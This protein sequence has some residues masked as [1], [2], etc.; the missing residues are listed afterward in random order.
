MK[1]YLLEKFFEPERWDY[2]ISKA[3]DK[4]MNRAVQIQ[5]AKPEIRIRLMEKIARGEYRITPPHTALIPKDTPGEF[6]TVYINEDVDRVLLSILNDL[7]FDLCPEMVHPR[8]KSYL[9]GTGCGKVVQGIS[10][11]IDQLSHT[12]GEVVGWKSDLSKY[13][14]SVPL[15][16]IDAAFDRVEDKF[17][18]S[19]V[20]DMVRAYYHCDWYI[21]TDWVPKQKY[22]SLK[23]GC[24][25]ASW[26]ADVLLYHIDDKLSRMDVRYERYSDDM[27]CI[28]PDYGKA[29]ETLESELAQMEM[30]L[31]PKKVEYLS[32]ERWF[33]FLGFSIKGKDISMSQTRLKKFQYEVEDRTLRKVRQGITYEAALK[34]VNRY[35]YGN[36]EFSWATAVLPIINVRHDVDELNKF[37]M[38]CL[39]AVKAKRSKGVGGLG[40]VKNQVIGCITR[41]RGRHV[42]SNRR[43]TSPILEGYRTIGCM[44]NAILTCRPAFDA[45]V[46]EM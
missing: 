32:S 33:K 29:M 25:V 44:Q 16:Y 43:K 17:G 30:K 2:A 22:Q 6:R 37:V 11:E 3:L 7:L 46:R 27:L 40:F 45:L 8:C 19:K 4:K 26:L 31:N 18:R 23:Q 10:R 20:I 42:S 5:L 12:P 34:D 39:R 41:G 9:R 38:D 13:F 15:P 14:D 28:G 35:L 21:D 1:D 36:G 24:S